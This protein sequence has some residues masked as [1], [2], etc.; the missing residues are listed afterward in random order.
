MPHEEKESTPNRR[1]SSAETEDQ[2][3]DI[4]SDADI[5]TG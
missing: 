2:S 3:R 4:L 5:S 1:Y